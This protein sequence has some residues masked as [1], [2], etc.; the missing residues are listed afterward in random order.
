MAED[1]IDFNRERN[2]PTSCVQIVK[3][4][5]PNDAVYY[6][7]Y[8]HVFETNRLTEAMDYFFL[9]N[10]TEFE[11]DKEKL[12]YFIF[13][14]Y[15][16]EIALDNFKTT[17]KLHHMLHKLLDSV[18]DV[19]PPLSLFNAFY[20]Y[21]LETRLSLPAEDQKK[22]QERWDVEDIAELIHELA[23][24]EN[25]KPKYPFA[26]YATMEE[27]RGE[28]PEPKLVEDIPAIYAPLSYWHYQH[29]VG[30]MPTDWDA[31]MPNF[32]KPPN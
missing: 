5:L 9:I 1:T 21:C 16:K 13:D 3:Y 28:I 8:Q 11:L 30:K 26:I 22:A 6:E 14:D 27:G 12:N 17:Y 29:T 15:P 20:G 31:R 18:D 10:S 2:T 7:P 4:D 24:Q 23:K 25:W 32:V 19:D